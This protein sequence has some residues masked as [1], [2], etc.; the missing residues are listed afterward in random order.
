MLC[1][2]PS[3]GKSALAQFL[4]D[5]FSKLGVIVHIVSE[6]EHTFTQVF[7]SALKSSFSKSGIYSDSHLERRLRDHLRTETQRLLQAT[8][9]HSTNSDSRSPLVILDGLNYVS[10]FRYELYCLSRAVQQTH[11]VVLC[12]VD[13]QTA[14][15][16]NAQR[17][18]SIAAYNCR[19]IL[20]IVECGFIYHCCN[21]FQ[22]EFNF[23]KFKHVFSSLRYLF[24]FSLCVQQM[25]NIL[26]K[27][28]TLW[29]RDSNARPPLSAGTRRFSSSSATTWRASARDRSLRPPEQT[30]A[31]ARAQRPIDITRRPLA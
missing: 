11:C 10:G 23:R 16:W 4:C 2:L 28:Y 24:K 26:P 18:D 9:S 6:G 13:G 29:P 7:G 14:L 12:D 30:R 20:L 22:F 8:D 17:P 1:G 3:S 19:C 5:H 15:M 31:P 21:C 27:L 25:S